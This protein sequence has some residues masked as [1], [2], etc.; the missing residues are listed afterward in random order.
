MCLLFA[1]KTFPN[2]N[3]A[4][5]FSCALTKTEPIIT[6]VLASYSIDAALKSLK[7]NDI[8]Y[9]AISTDVSDHDGLKLFPV[10]VQY[11]NLKNGGVQSKLLELKSKPNETADT[12]A[13]Y[14]RDVLEK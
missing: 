14:V 6:S 3:S 5:K 8:A 12:I 10:L 2:S 11:F 7:E 1:E 9:C 13:G 4:K